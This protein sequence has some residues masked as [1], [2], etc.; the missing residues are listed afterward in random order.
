MIGA[1]GC[2]SS[3]W[4]T[5]YDRAFAIL[6][7]SEAAGASDLTKP[8]SPVAPYSGKNYPYRR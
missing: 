8:F 1:R 4:H 5:I 6:N 7:H 3:L 2:E